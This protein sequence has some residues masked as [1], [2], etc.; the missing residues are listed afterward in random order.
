[1]DAAL[2]IILP[3][4]S[5]ASLRT[6]GVFNLV[7]LSLVAIRLLPFDAK[8]ADRLS[9]WSLGIFVPLIIWAVA[10]T[11]TSLSFFLLN[12]LVFLLLIS[13][14]FGGPSLLV[15]LGSL[16]LFGLAAICFRRISIEDLLLS[17]FSI[18]LVDKLSWWSVTP[19][20]TGL[21]NSFSHSISALG[22]LA[23][24]F[25]LLT[26]TKERITY[27]RSF[28]LFAIAV[29]TL[30]S[31]RHDRL[32][33]PTSYGH[34]AVIVGPAEMLRTGGKLLWDIPS[35]YGF[36]NTILIALLPFESVF[37]SFYFLNVLANLIAG[38]LLYSV[39]RN[40]GSS[41][42]HQCVAL[43]TVLGCY[44]L[45]PSEGERLM[46]PH[47]CPSNYAFRYFWVIALWSFLYHFQNRLLRSR[48][49]FSGSVLWFLGAI[50]SMESFAFVSATWLPVYF[51]FT[52]KKPLPLPRKILVLTF[53][54]MAIVTFLGSVSFFY[55]ASYGLWPDWKC[56]Y[57]FA[58]ARASGRWANLAVKGFGASWALIS[59]FIALQ[60]SLREELESSR[61]E[62]AVVLG[63][64]SLSLWLIA[65]TFV[66]RGTPAYVTL[67]FPFILLSFCF[68]HRVERKGFAVLF[69][70]LLALA[71]VQPWTN[72]SEA[73]HFLV[74]S[75]QGYHSQIDS[76]LP[77]P[78]VEI[79]NLTNRA[80]LR[81]DSR[82][83]YAT[84]APELVGDW[85]PPVRGKFSK[86]WLPAP[87]DLLD[88][89]PPDR[90]KTY[91]ERFS[92]RF[93]GPVWLLLERRENYD[94]KE[95]GPL[96]GFVNENYVLEAKFQS[97]R[98][99]L[100]KISRRE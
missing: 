94:V 90:R 31:L 69:A 45:L 61:K 46:S 100:L 68:A 75:F 4:V 43:L 70:P 2:R 6:L 72:S 1:L 36:A 95:I 10:R 39:F 34:W 44:F 14:C 49:L 59:S 52:G 18:C 63:A 88:A 71:I 81:E 93:Q 58:F 82:I 89:L 56:F 37:Q 99:D 64:I 66:S 15:S 92:Q 67:L 53:P 96:F 84:D 60:I 83:V 80:G 7:F 27:R 11:R 51:Y 48:Y 22:A 40:L 35:M 91:F 47:N 41:F 20:L 8:G 17:F 32:F 25:F 13:I 16:T 3:Y 85:L 30:I 5:R 55:K 76:F 9:H 28:D 77:E 23:L 33:D 87:G 98:Y 65:A 54:L 38:I 73:K 62:S 57:E 24:S 74:S 78:D 79:Q 26:D 86:P 42:F 29:I 12:V 21:L 50:W 97:P 19:G